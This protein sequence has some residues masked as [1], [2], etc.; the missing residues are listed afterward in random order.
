MNDTLGIAILVLLLVG[1]AFFVG[2]EF[3]LIS[4][5]R[6]M[7]EPRAAAGNRRARITLRAMEDVSLM[8]AGA[9][10]GITACSLGIGAIGE[11]AVAHLIEPFMADLGLPE[12][13][14][15]PVAFVIALSFVVVLHMVLGEMVPKNIAI[16]GPE[17][18]ALLLGPLLVGIVISLRPVIA[19]MNASA[20]A[21]LRL[22]GIAPADEVASAYTREQVANL[23]EESQ[24]EGMLDAEE[25]GLLEGALELVDTTASDVII[26]APDLRTLPIAASCADVETAVIETG[27]SRLPLL[28]DAGV[29]VAYVHVKDVLQTDNPAADQP[30]PTVLQRPLP[31]IE[32]DASLQEVVRELQS[33]GAHLGRV[34]EGGAVLGIIALEDALEEFI[35]EVSDAAHRG[36]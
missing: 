23:I 16:A 12:A 5:R 4:A 10:L 20:N 8:M 35:G 30:V 28:D 15:H 6:A 31:D 18:S 24:R 11:P 27:Y 9:Q 22:V 34:M 32:S 3:A 13:M 2:A 33:H 25:A 36:K 19:L 17:R 1:N 7:I 21:I 26:P 29:P 14:V